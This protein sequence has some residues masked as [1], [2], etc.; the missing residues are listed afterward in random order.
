MKKFNN[1]IKAFNSY[2]LVNIFIMLLTPGNMRGDAVFSNKLRAI[3]FFSVWKLSGEFMT[4]NLNFP[5]GQ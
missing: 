1:T 3:P 5:E 4:V 2:L